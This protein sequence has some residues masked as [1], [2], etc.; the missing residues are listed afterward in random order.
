MAHGQDFVKNKSA[1]G[2]IFLWKDCVA[3]LRRR[4]NVSK[5]M[6]RR[7]DFLTES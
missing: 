4:Q 3:G 2:K 5:K 1:A 7:Q 6:R